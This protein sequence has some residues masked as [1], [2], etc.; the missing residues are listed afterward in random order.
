MTIGIHNEAKKHRASYGVK[1]VKVKSTFSPLPKLCTCTLCSKMIKVSSI[2]NWHFIITLKSQLYKKCVT[3]PVH[4]PISDEIQSLLNT[5]G[6]TFLMTSHVRSVL[7]TLHRWW[8]SL[9]NKIGPVIKN[10]QFSN[11]LFFI[12]N[13]IEMKWL[14]Y[15]QLWQQVRCQ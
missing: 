5:S 6:A 10:N 9:R 15:L 3:W 4:W 14:I 12:S 11:L 2:S 7:W 1:Y 13:F 8:Y